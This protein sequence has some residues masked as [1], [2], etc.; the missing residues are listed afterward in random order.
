MN[1]EPLSSQDM[2]RLDEL[3]ARYGSE[4]SVMSFSELDGFLAAIVSGP[5]PV[6]PGQWLPWVWGDEN[7]QPAWDT[8]KEAQDFHALVLK[9]MNE[10]AQA[11]RGSPGDF[12]PAFDVVEMADDGSDDQLCLAPWCFGYMRAVTLCDWPALPEDLHHWLALIEQQTYPDEVK[13]LLA[14]GLDAQEEMASELTLA[15]LMLQRYWLEQE[16]SEPQP[17]R[18]GPRVAREEPCPCGSGKQYQHCCLH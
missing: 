4:A 6:L 10:H 2:N 15:A 17:G 8:N 1:Q 18:S 16:L 14:E 3:L 9:A 11:L 12:Q 5:E 13:R 7:D